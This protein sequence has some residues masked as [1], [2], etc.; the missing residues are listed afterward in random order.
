MAAMLITLAS[1]AADAPPEPAMR[2]WLGATT[3]TG[4]HRGGSCHA[5]FDACDLA[6]SQLP[7]NSE[8]WCIPMLG[9]PAELVD[10]TCRGEQRK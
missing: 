7:E 8:G 10:S 2:Y 3:A 1:A 6:R 9:W 4:E 5:T